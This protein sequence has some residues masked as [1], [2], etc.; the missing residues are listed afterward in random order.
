MLLKQDKEINDALYAE[1]YSK[2][3]ISGTSYLAYRDLPNMI[4]RYVN[5]KNVLDYGSGAG[6]STLFLKSLGYKVMSVDINDKM[7]E[8]AKLGS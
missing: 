4:D 6:E 2:Y 5:G 8:I 3:K 7:L 1:L